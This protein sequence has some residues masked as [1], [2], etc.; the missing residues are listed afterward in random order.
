[1]KEFHPPDDRTAVS[2]RPQACSHRIDWGGPQQSFLAHLPDLFFP[3]LLKL[4]IEVRLPDQLPFLLYVVLFVVD[5]LL[6]EPL[7]VVIIK[8]LCAVAG[9]VDAHRPRVLAG[10]SEPLLLY[11]RQSSESG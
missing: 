9:K 3:K 2:F 4:K 6:I 1:M 10:R 11:A 7:V 8:V 5:G